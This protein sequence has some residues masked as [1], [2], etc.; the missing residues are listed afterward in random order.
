MNWG[1]RIRL[2][3]VGFGIGIFICWMMF[4]R[5]GGR[6][7]SGWLPGSRVLKFIGLSR[8]ISADSALLC[9]MKCEGISTED[10]RKATIDGDVDF[11][12]SQTDKVPDKEYDVKLKVKGKDLEFYFSTNMKDSTVKILQIY[13]P[14]DGTKCDCK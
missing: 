2:Y 12:K 9:K 3:L 5:N 7:L 4:F 8:S 10:I 1:R 6:D 13:P 14:L 11:S